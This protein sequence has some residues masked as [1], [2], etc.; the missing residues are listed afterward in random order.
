MKTYLAPHEPP[1]VGFY[2]IRLVRGGPF[3]PARIGKTG[4]LWWAEI[5]G[6][7]QAEPHENPALALAT[8]I[9]LFGEPISPQVYNFMVASAAH[10]RDHDPKAPAA[11]PK[12]K[13]DLGKLPAI[14]P[15]K[16]G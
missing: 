15:T 9:Q 3:V 13:I 16:R 14:R 11:N 8:K 7:R 10:A 2:R 5:D 1:K 6:V 4:R 12:T